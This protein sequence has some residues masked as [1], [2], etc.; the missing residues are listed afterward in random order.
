MKMQ[1]G[2]WLKSRLKEIISDQPAPSW[3]LALLDVSEKQMILKKNTKNH[4]EI[5]LEE[6]LIVGIIREKNNH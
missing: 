5:T 2:H 1:A 6:T 4:W 3:H